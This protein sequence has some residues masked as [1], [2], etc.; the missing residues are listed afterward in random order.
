MA[1]YTRQTLN[2]D[3]INRHPKTGEEMSQGL[4][5][6]QELQT[7]IVAE[8]ERMSLSYGFAPSVLSNTKWSSLK[9]CIHK[10]H[11]MDTKWTL[12]AVFSYTD[13]YVYQIERE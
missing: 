5:L 3:N 1:A 10:P 2:N 11:Q 13:V 4:T 9:S 12:Q 6:D 8:K 7:I